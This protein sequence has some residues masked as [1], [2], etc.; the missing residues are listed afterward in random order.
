M[1][2]LERGV[3]T[4]SSRVPGLWRP[5][6][7]GLTQVAD[8]RKNGVTRRRT[9]PSM[10]QAIKG[11]T[12]KFN[13]KLRFIASHSTYSFSR[14]DTI[15]PSPTPPSLARLS[16]SISHILTTCRYQDRDELLEPCCEG[17]GAT[18]VSLYLNDSPKIPTAQPTVSA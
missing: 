14:V 16:S 17:E 5:F 3:V 10:M 15:P 13:V 11:S 12:K 18:A 4:A 2:L 9:F 1:E 6:V 8:A 7:S